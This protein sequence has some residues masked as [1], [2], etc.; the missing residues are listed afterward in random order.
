MKRFILWT[1]LALPALCGTSLVM[2]DDA[3]VLPARIGRVYLAPV[4]A[5]ANGSYNT[6]GTYKGFK[7]GGGTMR[8]FGLGVAAEYGITNWATAAVQWTPAWMLASEVDVTQDIPNVGLV[9][10]VNANGPGDLFIGAKFL[11]IGK[12]A[13]VENSRIRFAVATGVKAPIPGADFEDQLD[14]VRKGN[15][16]TAANQDKHVLG[17]GLRTYAD[18]VFNERFFLNF[19]TEFIGYPIKGK[20]SESGITGAATIYNL[21]L[22]RQQIK[23][24]LI[25]SGFY[26]PGIENDII[27][28]RDE[29][30][31][32]YELNLELEPAFSTSLGRG[33]N[34]SAG[35]PLNFHYAPAERYDV[36]VNSSYLVSLQPAL[37][38]L[39]PQSN[40]SKLFSLRPGM[41]FFFTG[42][43]LPAEV[44][45]AY[46]APLAGENAMATHTVV[47][48]VRLYFRL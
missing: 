18:Y 48:Q 43:P 17:L 1:L 34:F 32:G 14:N 40:P 8:A 12:H 41:S 22:A 25:N 45:L 13:P 11:L 16:V 28:Y 42:F 19:Y 7:R 21:G 46:Y 3:S 9:D 36:S 15:T 33:V 6:N 24:E 2:A 37:A 39:V 5:F 35:L 30:R 31:Y 27:D 23:A 26:T 10:G 29:V 4:F 44:K 20:L 38:Q 47:L